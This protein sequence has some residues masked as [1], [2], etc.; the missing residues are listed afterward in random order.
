[1]RERDRPADPS[2]D[3]LGERVWKQIARRE[4][5]TVLQYQLEKAKLVSPGHEARA[6]EWV[7]AILGTIG[8]AYEAATR[9]AVLRY[10]WLRCDLEGEPVSDAIPTTGSARLDD[11]IRFAWRKIPAEEMERLRARAGQ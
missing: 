3:F 6:R 2:T 4:A 5:I 1:M 7:D 11:I 10:V 8:P 9:D